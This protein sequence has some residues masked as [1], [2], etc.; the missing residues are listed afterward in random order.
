[1]PLISDLYYYTTMD[2]EEDPDEADETGKG[3]KKRLPIRSGT[4]GDV[5]QGGKTEEQEG[6]PGG[7][8]I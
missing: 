4:F 2:Y 7:K 6:I 5:G 8:L 1:L 3:T